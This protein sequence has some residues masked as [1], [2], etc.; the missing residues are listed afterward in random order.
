ML[1]KQTN[2]ASFKLERVKDRLEEALEES[3]RDTALFAKKLETGLTLMTL[4]F[5]CNRDENK[6]KGNALKYKQE[7]KVRSES[8]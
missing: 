8:C 7:A 2:L 4:K 3:K 5:C 1:R 6:M